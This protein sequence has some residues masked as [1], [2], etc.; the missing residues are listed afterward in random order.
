V[1]KYVTVAIE[2]A[3]HAQLD[4]LKISA[5]PKFDGGISRNYWELKGRCRQTSRWNREEDEDSKRRAFRV[6]SCSY[7]VE[8]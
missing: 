6:E 2:I 8:R 1:I 3:D 7:R 5:E 4:E